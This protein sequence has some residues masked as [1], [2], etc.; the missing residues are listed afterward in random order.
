MILALTLS[1]GSNIFSLIGPKLSG[2]AIDNLKGGAGYVVFHKIFYYC[3]LMAAFYIASSIMAYALSVLMIHISQKIVHQ[4]RK[5]V[6]D[7]L[8]ELPVSYYDTHQTG[9]SSAGYPMISI[10]SIPR[11]QQISYRSVQV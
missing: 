7:S 11:F 3:W 5:D 4:M 8:M 2:L 9:R 6:Y 10:R 1:V